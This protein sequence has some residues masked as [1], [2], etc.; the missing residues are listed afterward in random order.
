MTDHDPD[1]STVFAKMCTV[2]T[3][4]HLRDLEAQGLIAAAPVYVGDEGDLNGKVV[5]TQNGAVNDEWITLTCYSC[6][7]SGQIARSDL[8]EFTDP[9]QPTAACPQCAGA[10]IEEEEEGLEFEAYFD[11]GRGQ[12]NVSLVQRPTGWGAIEVR[13]RSERA[14]PLHQAGSIVSDLVQAAVDAAMQKIAEDIMNE[15]DPRDQQ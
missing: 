9:D 11:D 3:P 1:T 12:I 13:L 4:E 7:Q 14:F 6:G 15:E 10:I 5:I 8:P 2:E